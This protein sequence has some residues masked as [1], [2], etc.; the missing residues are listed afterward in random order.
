M[1]DEP[2]VFITQ[3]PNRRDPNTGA[4]V[5]AFDAMPAAEHGE[6]VV[7]MPA[8]FS[9]FNTSEMVRQLRNTLV[10]YS[11]TRGDAVVPAG[12]PAIIFATGAVLAEQHR[13]M[14][15]LKW[16]RSVKRYVP[17]EVSL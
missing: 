13:K 17:V 14:R 2:R 5:P 3:I 12:D 4:M 6:I 10:D 11:F 7:L 1:K 9:L 8:S 15:I 16:E